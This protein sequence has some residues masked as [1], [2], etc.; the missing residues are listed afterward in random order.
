MITPEDYARWRATAVGRLTEQ[1]EQDAVFGLFGDLR[2]RTVLDVA[3]GD[4]TYSISACKRGARVFGVDH[5]APMIEAAR[6]RA[7]DC[8][9]SIE[10]CL[11][12]TEELPFDSQMFD[13]VIAVTALCF[14]KD[15][16]RTIQEAACVL[17]PGGSLIIG[18][19]GRYGLWAFPRKIRGWLGSSTWSG[20][21]FWTFQNLR[22]LIEQA[23]LRFHPRRTS[24]YFP[25]VGRVAQLLGPYNNAFSPLGQFA[26]AFLTFRADKV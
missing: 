6:H 19:L 4:G 15:P 20:V 23:G 9:G 11:A 26:A 3:C 16:R 2:K 24:V 5:S 7:E 22:R 1:L 14:V 25:P 21:H 18:E 13:D 12:S 8:R 10:W 17:Q